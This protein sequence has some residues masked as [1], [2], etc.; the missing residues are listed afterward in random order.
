MI[1]L[2]IPNQSF[3]TPASQFLKTI[4]YMSLLFD[5]SL[6]INKKELIIAYAKNQLAYTLTIKILY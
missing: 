3:T 5:K 1:L 4:L 6:F 2:L